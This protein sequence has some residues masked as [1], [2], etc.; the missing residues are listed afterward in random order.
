M[1]RINKKL[2]RAFGAATDDEIK[3]FSDF[4]IGNTM[5]VGS[6]KEISD[7]QILIKN[8]I[9]EETFGEDTH[10]I[11]KSERKVM[12]LKY[13]EDFKFTKMH[14]TDFYDKP[15]TRKELKPIFFTKECRLYQYGAL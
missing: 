3:I 9:D 6:R 2:K 15:Q 5:M 1:G 14:S 4:A 10:I 7:T 13:L 8:I 11:P 12:L